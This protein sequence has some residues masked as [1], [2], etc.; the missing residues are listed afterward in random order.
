MSRGNLDVDDLLK[1][2]LVLVIIWLALEVLEA[3]VGT[4]AGI[5]H[6]ATPVVG[7]V[8]LALLVLWLL[9]RI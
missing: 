8:V 4:L 2:V 1:I 6:L 7:L 5:L 9:D 3:I